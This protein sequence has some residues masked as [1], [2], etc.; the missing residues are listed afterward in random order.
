MASK[1][2]QKRVRTYRWQGARVRPAGVWG[3]EGG[4]L[5]H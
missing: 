1:V 2:A 3:N 4:A 5:L